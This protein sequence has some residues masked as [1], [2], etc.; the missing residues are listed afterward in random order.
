MQGFTAR[1]P[2]LMATSAFGLG[3]RR[4]S[5]SSTVLSTLSPCLQLKV[6]RQELPSSTV[7]VMLT[8]DIDTAWYRLQVGLNDWQ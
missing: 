2:L 3:T 5:S 7:L 4:W 6:V 1:M 8:I